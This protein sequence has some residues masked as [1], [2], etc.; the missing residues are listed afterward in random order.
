MA[1]GVPEFQVDRHESLG[2]LR[3]EL[4][5]EARDF[6]LAALPDERAIFRCEMHML[7]PEIDRVGAWTLSAFWNAA[8]YV[9]Q[10][11]DERSDAVVT[12]GRFLE[13][14]QKVLQNYGGL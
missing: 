5:R 2:A 10:I 6:S 1:G 9:N 4:G 3:S 7:P 11:E 8:I 12:I 13:A 14:T